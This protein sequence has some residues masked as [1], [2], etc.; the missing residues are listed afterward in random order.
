MNKKNR[1]YDNA[2]IGSCWLVLVLTA[3]FT[4]FPPKITDVPLK[5]SFDL[6]PAVIGDWLYVKHKAG[7]DSLAGTLG[8]D[9]LLLRTYEDSAKNEVELYCAYF[10]HIEETKE[11]GPHPPQLCWVGSGWAF[12]DLGDEVIRL[13]VPKKVT[14]ITKVIY[15]QRKDQKLLL[16]YCYKI[17]GRYVVDFGQLKLYAV[18]DTLFK[19]KNCA[20]SL[21]LTTKVNKD[22]VEKTRSMMKPL[23]TK[24]LSLLEDQFLP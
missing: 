4:Y 7:F 10:R 23:L 12:K 8:A 1:F 19:R 22:D 18:R 3:L 11:K 13:E 24:I 9:D 17:N 16:Y 6:F 2:V 20:F 15:A 14:A 5:A 21:Q